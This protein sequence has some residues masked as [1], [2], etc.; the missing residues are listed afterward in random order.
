M[1]ATIAESKFE[2]R[3]RR[4][5]RKVA[6]LHVCLP[7]RLFWRWFVA[8]AMCTMASAG[9]AHRLEARR[10][11]DAMLA[12]RGLMPSQFLLRA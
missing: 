11:L 12:R 4:L 1:A 8:E 10:R 3:L 7:R 9:P 2:R 5:D 6:L